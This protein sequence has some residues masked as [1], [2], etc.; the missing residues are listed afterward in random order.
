MELSLEIN[1]EW[2]NFIQ[3]WHIQTHNYGFTKEKNWR[4]PDDKMDLVG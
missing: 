2:V 1:S 4:L 3:Q